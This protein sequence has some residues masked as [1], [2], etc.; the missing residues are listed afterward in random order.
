[1]NC[2]LF[3]VVA[4]CSLVSF[5]LGQCYNSRVRFVMRIPQSGENMALGFMSNMTKRE[6]L[7]KIFADDHFDGE[8][9]SYDTFFDKWGMV[10]ERIFIS[11]YTYG[12]FKADLCLYILHDRLWQMEI[13][14]DEN[15]IQ[16][17]EEDIYKGSGEILN[18][19]I[20]ITKNG[21]CII[22]TDERFWE[23]YMRF[24][25]KFARINFQEIPQG[26]VPLAV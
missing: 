17:I 20:R 15:V 9:G 26:H 10:E 25:S 22:V 5:G 4:V 1:M 21:S 13:I 18:N 16:Q 3:L 24:I 23:E 14:A 6:L 12:T 19:S 7:N 11:D 8:I 2:R